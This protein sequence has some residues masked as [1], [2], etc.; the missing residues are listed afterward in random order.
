MK[1]ASKKLFVQSIALMML[2]ANDRVDAQIPKLTDL[3][4]RL[5]LQHS[6]DLSA[7][8]TGRE[9]L[10]NVVSGGEGIPGPANSALVVVAVRGAPNSHVGGNVV[11]LLITDQRT[12]KLVN[13]MTSRAGRPGSTGESHVGFWLQP[14]GCEPLV[15]AASTEGSSISLTLPFR[16]GE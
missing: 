4:V 1:A 12:G 16:C 11:Q 3:R 2:L 14:I 13:R 15:L 9:D 6:G 8:L 7:P 5:F 10:W